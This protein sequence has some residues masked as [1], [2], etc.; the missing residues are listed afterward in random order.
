M[1]RATSIA[2]GLACAALALSLLLLILAAAGVFGKSAYDIAV[3]NG[4][5]GDQQQWLQSLNGSQGLSAYD[6]YVKSLPDG[7]Q[8]LTQEQWLQS[9]SGRR[10]SV[11]YS[12]SGEPDVQL[13]AQNGDFYLRIYSDFSDR[14][15]I[16]IYSYAGSAWTVIAD[17]SSQ[18]SQEEQ[19]KL[20]NYHIRTDGD[21]EAF[22]TAI[23]GEQNEQADDFKGKTVYLDFDLNLNTDSWQSLGTEETPFKGVF[24]GQGHS[25][26]ITETAVARMRSN[27]AFFGFV[28][29]GAKI[30]DFTVK[31]VSADGSKLTE[32]TEWNSDGEQSEYFGIDDAAALALLRDK[33][34]GGETF[35]DSTVKL[36]DDIDLSGIDNWQPIGNGEHAFGGTFD[37]D[38]HTVSHL[39]CQLDGDYVGLFG[40]SSKATFRNVT[41][42]DCTL[43]GSGYIGALVGGS[44]PSGLIDNVTVRNVTATGNH[45]I[46]GVIGAGYITVQNCKA[47]DVNITASPNAL[48]QGGYDNG[49]KIGGIA[50]QIREYDTIHNCAVQG[51]TLY[52]YRDMGGVAGYAYSPAEG[53][54]ATDVDITVDQTN[55]YE[56]KPANVGG[57]FGYS[58]QGNS[59][60]T[61]DNVRYTFANV[62]ATN[63]QQLLDVLALVNSLNPVSAHIALDDGEYTATANEQLKITADN[64][65]LTGENAQGTVINAGAYTCSGQ[66]AMEVSGD[67]CTI[68]QLTVTCA[69]MSNNVSVLKVSELNNETDIV[70]NF[71]VNNVILDNTFDGAQG[72]GLNL[73]GVKGADVGYVDVRNYGKCAISL[74]KATD[75]NIYECDFTD[76]DE[77]NWA[78]IG[79]MYSGASVDAYQTAS[80][81]TIDFATCKFGRNTNGSVSVY[82]ERPYASHDSKT[83]VLRDASA[84]IVNADNAPSGWTYTVSNNGA[85]A[86]TKQSSSGSALQNN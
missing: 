54:S 74:A 75:V 40:N 42:S 30:V 10:G 3:K 25:A 38:G 1:K 37:G 32:V 4:Y 58:S 67:N 44:F 60:G 47:Y 51:V 16:A 69:P 7:E 33:V 49:D 83:D 13:S 52:G 20:T 43:G 12:G 70:N 35:A 36:T 2:I 50:G 64:V 65:T 72:H 19:S 59:G 79:F 26:T 31:V 18:L 6:L 66:A 46:G 86:L 17:T 81:V 57:I 68:S 61:T 85:W 76:S 21:V 29:D 55:F 27:R 56:Y 80:D 63:S 77:K 28:D 71:T 9:L 62:R 5:K 24:N 48:E 84:G 8:A 78:N 39:T 11:W 82:S 73:H 22:R 15:G 45:Y 34:N 14:R 41:L 53:H 23:S